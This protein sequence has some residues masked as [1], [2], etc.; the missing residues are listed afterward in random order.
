M[1]KEG[2]SIGPEGN[3]LKRGERGDSK[4][5]LLNE[6]HPRFFKGQSYLS[7]GFFRKV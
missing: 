1:Y 5:G 7:L 4:A 2:T 6:S 3:T